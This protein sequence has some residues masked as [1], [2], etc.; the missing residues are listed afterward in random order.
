MEKNGLNICLET[1]EEILNES[2]I[3]ILESSISRK[4]AV[5]VVHVDDNEDSFDYLQLRVNDL[6]IEIDLDV[7]ELENYLQRTK[8]IIRDSRRH[9]HG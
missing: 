8:K 2:S 5:S 6:G 7:E 9:N 1:E 3:Y 4:P